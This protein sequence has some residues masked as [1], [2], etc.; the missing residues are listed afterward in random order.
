MTYRERIMRTFKKEKIDRIVWQPR[1][2][3]WFYGNRLKNKLPNGYEDS[4]TLDAL[5][6]NIQ[7]YNGSVPERYKNKTM[8]EVY[9]DLNASPRYPQEVLGVNIFKLEVDDASGIKMFVTEDKQGERTT[10]IETP[11]GT[12]KEVTR[13]GYHTEY[14]VKTPKDY[15]VMKYILDNTEFQFDEE[16]FEIAD[17]EFGKRGVVQS[18]YPRSPLQRLIID[19]MG[20]KNTIL[21]LNYH[22]GEI[23]EFLGAIEEWDDRMY[24]VLLNSPLKVLNFGENIDAN[25]DSPRLFEEYLVPYYKKRVKQI[26]QNNK[27]CHIHMDGSL[28]PLLPL[29]NEIDFDGIEAATPQPQGD[30]TLGE[31]KEA[32]GDTILLD[33]IPAL[34]FLPEYPKKE[35]EEFAV[36]VLEL[37]SPNLILG[38]SDELP[39]NA[40]I[41][42]VRLVSDIVENYQV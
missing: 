38:I 37:F 7:P 35:L 33:G 18:F 19:Y 3:Y 6:S 16:A 41:E 28:K 40:D 23:E 4:K 11:E 12:L 34:L 10:V 36:Q 1:I 9:D 26:H 31:L 5:Y 15:K 27:F 21:A 20:F 30:V 14:P 42:K 8:I 2:Y 22:P 24:K 25:L 17:R 29:L 13:H 32:M 39:P